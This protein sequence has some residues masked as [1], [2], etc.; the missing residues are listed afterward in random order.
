M[1]TLTWVINRRK[2]Y[3]KSPINNVDKMLRDGGTGK[4]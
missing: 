4:E 3:V 1:F 2:R